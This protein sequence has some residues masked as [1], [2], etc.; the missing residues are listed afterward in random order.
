[1]P[2]DAAHLDERPSR[3]EADAAVHTLVRWAGELALPEA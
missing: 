2:S 1:V 3:E